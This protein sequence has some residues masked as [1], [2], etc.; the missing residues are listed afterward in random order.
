MLYVLEEALECYM[1][2][3]ENVIV[4]EMMMRDILDKLE[5]ITKRC[6]KCHN[7]DGDIWKDQDA[8]MRYVLYDNA[9]DDVINMMYDHEREIFSMYKEKIRVIKKG[10]NSIRYD[11]YSD[12]KFVYIYDHMHDYLRIIENEL[13]I[14]YKMHNEPYGEIENFRNHINVDDKLFIQE[15]NMR[16][17]YKIE[18][19]RETRYYTRIYNL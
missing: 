3:E 9:P 5:S 18:L 13:K 12:E 8:V 15:H 19:L 1:E 14:L 16:L 4:L 2:T 11:M 7:R 17:Y 10:I 6:V